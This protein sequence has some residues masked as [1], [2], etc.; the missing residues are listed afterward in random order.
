MTLSANIPDH[1]TD[2][3]PVRR[4]R[5]Q[6]LAV[7]VLLLPA[8]IG[9]S[10]ALALRAGDIRPELSS[11]ITATI[12][13][14]GCIAIL[15]GLSSLEQYPHTRLGACNMVTLLRGAGIAL[16]A[17]LIPVAHSDFGWALAG[18]AALLLAL[19]GVDG[20]LARRS[21]LQSPFGARFDVES[22]VAFALVTACLAVAIGHVGVWFVLLGLLRPLFL[23]AAYLWPLLDAPLPEAP[24]RKRIAG[25]Q[26][27]VQV[28][29]LAPFA[30]HPLGA[31]VGAG[32]LLI[33][34]TSFSIDIVWLIRNRRTP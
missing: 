13:L 22:D 4:A 34:L 25:L 16:M 26:M 29:L 27:A 17:G 14:I 6:A 19:D 24:R 33:T 10:Y 5:S 20:W 7:M 2:K 1:D 12:S 11:A 3:P 23:G 32:V 30:A 28:A 21:A 8:T 18:F 15:R 31:A 9:A